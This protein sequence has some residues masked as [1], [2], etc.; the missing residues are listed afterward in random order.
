M[1]KSWYMIDISADEDQRL[2]HHL[3]PDQP[4]GLDVLE[5]IGVK[6]WKVRTFV[7]DAYYLGSFS[8]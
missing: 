4:V 7:N 2:P 6:Y 1:V 5:N 8:R 3:E